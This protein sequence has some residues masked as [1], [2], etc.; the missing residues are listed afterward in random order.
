LAEVFVFFAKKSI[1]IISDYVIK[2]LSQPGLWFVKASKTDLN[3]SK[4]VYDLTYKGG[5]PVDIYSTMKKIIQTEVI[6]MIRSDCIG[7]ASDE[8]ERNWLEQE[9]SE[10]NT[11]GF[12]WYPEEM[13]DYIEN[14]QFWSFYAI[15]QEYGLRLLSCVH[16]LILVDGLI[17]LEYEEES[18]ILNIL[19]MLDVDAKQYQKSVVIFLSESYP[20]EIKRFVEMRQ[21]N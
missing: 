18:R 14:G 6:A 4:F 17:D 3:I 20:S 2:K 10:Y 11:H 12:F 21:L 1:M 7:S 8:K 15:F 5:I 19:A 9:M 13:N 16:R